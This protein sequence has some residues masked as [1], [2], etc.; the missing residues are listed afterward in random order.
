MRGSLPIEPPVFS[1]LSFPFFSCHEK[2]CR[3]TG[4]LPLPWHGG[5]TMFLLR[6]V[7]EGQDNSASDPPVAGPG[8]P[9]PAPPHLRLSVHAP[10][11]RK[12]QWWWLIFHPGHSCLFLGHRRGK[13]REGRAVRCAFCGVNTW[14]YHFSGGVD[15]LNNYSQKECLQATE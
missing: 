7:S 1:F 15:F 6:S 4:V 5:G 13:P 3:G 11:F 8:P 2:A 9:L 10:C 12:R 14:L